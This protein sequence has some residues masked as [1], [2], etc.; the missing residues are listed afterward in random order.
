M[1]IHEIRGRVDFGIITIREDELEAV[2]A[3]FPKEDVADGRRR[4]YRIRRLPLAAG[5]SYTI[6]VV[7]CAE[8]GTG[9]ALN[10]ARDLLEDLDPAFL[11]VVGI[12]GGVPADEFTLGDVIVSTRITDFSVE[13]VLSDH[14]HEYALGG[15]PL[16]PDATKLAADVRAME[17]DGDLTGW[18]DRESIRMDRPPVETGEGCFY[19]NDDWKKKVRAAL[20]RHFEGKPTR[21]PLVVAGSVASSDR[22]IKEA[23]TLQVWLKIARQ[24]QAVEMESA[25]V[26]KAAHGRVP[27]L[28]IRGISDVVGFKRHADW[29]TYACHSAAAF[30]RALL[31]TRPIP[32][33][34]ASRSL[35]SEDPERAA[36]N[37]Q[38]SAAKVVPPTMLLDFQAADADLDETS[39]LLKDHQP[40]VARALLE[41]IQRRQGYDL[42]PGR[43]FRLLSQLA[44][45]YF[46]E[47]DTGKAERHFLEAKK[48]QP[49]DEKARVNEARIYEAR[50]D[51]AQAREL[52]AG[53]MADF[54]A[55]GPALALWL[56]TA[57]PEESAEE[58]EKHLSGVHEQCEEAQLAVAMRAGQCDD[59]PRSE[60]LAR[61][62]ISND[63]TSVYARLLLAQVMYQSALRNVGPDARELDDVARARLQSSA[64]LLDELIAYPE[65]QR[66]KLWRAECL[67]ARARVLHVLDEI[68]QAERDFAETARLAPD[69]AIVELDYGRFLWAQQRYQE[70]IGHL[71]AAALKGSA[72]SDAKFFLAL[73]LRQRSAQGDAARSTALL[74]DVA[75]DNGND[76]AARALPMAVGGLV[77]QENFSEARSL[78][79]TACPDDGSLLLKLV[80]M[81]TISV[82]EEDVEAA[83]AHALAALKLWT[84]MADIDVTRRLVS[85]FAKLNRYVDALP[86][87][88]H[89]FGITRDPRDAHNVIACAQA[90]RRDDLLLATFRTMREAGHL[91]PDMARYEIDLLARYDISEA[92]QVLQDFVRAHPDDRHARLV[93]AACR[94]R[95]GQQ[96]SSPMP[97][98][99]LPPPGDLDPNFGEHVIRLLKK[100]HRPRDAVRY[101]Y[102]LVRHHYNHQEAHRALCSAML[103]ADEE[104]H[105]EETW[106]FDSVQVGA[107]VCYELSG[108]TAENWC[109][110][111][112]APKPMIQ[113]DEYAPD[114]DWGCA[115]IGKRVGDP[116]NVPGTGRIPRTGTIK[117]IV[118]E[119]VFRFN[120]SMR[121]MAVDFGKETG[122][123]VGHFGADK[124]LK[125]EEAFKPLLAQLDA[126]HTHEVVTDETYR[127]HVMS[128]HQFAK[129]RGRSDYEGYQI[130]LENKLNIRCRA[131]DRTQEID[132]H[133]WIGEAGTVVVD[134]T[135]IF[136]LHMLEQTDL[137]KSSP[138]MSFIVTQGTLEELRNAE[139]VLRRGRRHRSG[140]ARAGTEYRWIE[141]APELADRMYQQMVTTLETVMACCTVASGRDLAAVAAEDREM[142]ISFFGWHGAE[143]LAIATANNYVLWTDD[144]TLEVVGRVK[145]GLKRRVWTQ[146][147][148]QFVLKGEANRER[149]GLCGAKLLGWGY[150]PVSFDLDIVLQAGEL[151]R[152]NTATWPLSRA[153]ESFS[154]ES[155]NFS[156]W[157]SIARALIC[158]VESQVVVNP[159]AQDTYRRMLERLKG[160]KEPGAESTVESMLQ[161]LPPD[162]R[163]HLEVSRRLGIWGHV[164]SS[165][166]IPPGRG[167]RGTR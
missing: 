80:F 147:M 81:G 45:S 44:Y 122:W 129:M 139:E 135:A 148:L 123:V 153:I 51:T 163:A 13:A 18:N 85:V 24:I 19:G 78:V 162:V 125:P 65:V 106:T 145:L 90:A 75:Q 138:G 72:P 98:D 73:C 87:C 130:L 97:L 69:N 25:G 15:G 76:F 54:P 77:E 8:Q 14:S 21:P 49:H 91:P 66:S 101:G 133:S 31:L 113:L 108:E 132:V 140:L 16:H 117:E 100:L 53:I 156:T 114:H 36:N 52:A 126:S 118:S 95:L 154:D 127:S 141:V 55:S 115:L 70:A 104:V 1:D 63:P 120:N 111:T 29:T 167:S 144:I 92:V 151:A 159:S 131:N 30:T 20:E 50:G 64:K 166:P 32:P 23:E 43:R 82:A 2:L 121:R 47:G 10:T 74:V 26:Y 112:D 160:R 35:T 109:V 150:S 93:L 116:F 137:L 105:D 161:A 119:Y 155:I 110:I 40:E 71:E 94:L 56:R 142:L 33:R 62:V 7:R 96:D 84:T 88:E 3:R 46:M 11:L 143:S 27:F 86:L 17:S 48:L 124:D 42:P 61:A 9:D 39:K 34:A 59:F 79:S 146:A 99:D 22:L 136:T 67:L 41:R 128:I 157:L 60:R 165:I 38:S 164:P 12:A 58:Q 83:S 102:A 28:A 158:W 68:S 152:W 4:R 6:A 57:P 134:L 107:A 149:R 37:P 89:L 103:P 5:D